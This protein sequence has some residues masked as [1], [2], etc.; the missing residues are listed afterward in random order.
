[1]SLEHR[2]LIVNVHN[3]DK[4]SF[5]HISKNVGECKSVI[6]SILRKLEETGS[7]EAKK[8]LVGLGKQLQVKTDGLIQFTQP[9]RSGRM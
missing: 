5:G 1:M 4:L 3:E 6:Q 2:K 7:Y 8:P 9:L